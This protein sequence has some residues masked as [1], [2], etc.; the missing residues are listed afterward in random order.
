MTAKN[1][2]QFLW[3]GEGDHEVGNGQKLRL[4]P[5]LPLLSMV[6]ATLRAGAMST[7]VP[8]KVLATTVCT[9]IETATPL[10]GATTHD[11]SRSRTV[12]GQDPAPVLATETAHVGV[13]PAP[14]DTGQ[15]NQSNQRA[16]W[17]E[18][19]GGSLGVSVRLS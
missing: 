4:L 1:L 7:A 10:R 2:T 8:G 14:E 15:A 11:G 13:P 18:W 16:R 9:L 3:D 19:M 17:F 5:R 12:R 6:L